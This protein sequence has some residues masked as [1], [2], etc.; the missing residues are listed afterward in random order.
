LS[1]YTE[2][3]TEQDKISQILPELQSL[4]ANQQYVGHQLV[5]VNF[6]SHDFE[7]EERAIAT[8]REVWDDKLYEG[9]YPDIDSPVLGQRGPYSLDVT[10]TIQRFP[11]DFGPRW[12]VVSAS[13]SQPMPE[14]QM[15]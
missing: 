11:S 13:Y 12:E 14:W 2:T 6:I 1:V 3:Q 8:V 10:Y 4:K 15:N 9:E 7:S 5:S